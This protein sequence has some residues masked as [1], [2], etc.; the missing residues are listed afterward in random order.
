MTKNVIDNVI[1]VGE[2]T[3]KWDTGYSNQILKNNIILFINMNK[4]C[5][6]CSS[7]CIYFN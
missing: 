7:C 5:A 4:I 1:D 3:C 2:D 6:K